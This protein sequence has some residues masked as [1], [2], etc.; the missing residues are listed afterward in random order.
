M[1]PGAVAML[2][3]LFVVPVALLALGH[4][5]RR[6][7]YRQRAVFWGAAIGYLVASCAALVAGMIPPESWSADD[8]W[9]GLLGF[10][11][12]LIGP[13]IGAVAGV[14]KARTG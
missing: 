6:R 10:W 11:S 14:A 12:L 3:G 7:T 13:A 8:R 1:S 9:R 2:A 5:L 4:R